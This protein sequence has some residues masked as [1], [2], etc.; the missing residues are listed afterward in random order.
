MIPIGMRSESELSLLIYLYGEAAGSTRFRPSTAMSAASAFSHSSSFSA[1]SI[2]F[3]PASR[4]NLSSWR[5]PFA[6]VCSSDSRANT[7]CRSSRAP[8]GSS[9]TRFDNAANASAKTRLREA[10]RTPW[11]PLHASVFHAVLWSEEG[12][13][14]GRGGVTGLLVLRRRPAASQYRPESFP[15]QSSTSSEGNS[16]S[17]AVLRL[18]VSGFD[19]ETKQGSACRTRGDKQLQ[20][21]TAALCHVVGEC[22]GAGLGRAS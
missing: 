5:L 12:R 16:W 11:N 9:S 6:A 19:S 7:A 10:A 8:R 18:A 17:A 21:A 13:E 3:S 14:G 22:L 2:S 20:H 15:R 1:S 4:P